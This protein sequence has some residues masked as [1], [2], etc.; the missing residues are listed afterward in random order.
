MA[1][2]GRSK[3]DNQTIAAAVREELARKRISRAT[4]ASQARISLSSLEKALSGQRPFTDQSLIRIEEALNRRLRPHLNAA[5]QFAPESLGSYARPAVAWLE[6]DYLTLRPSFSDKNCLYAYRTQIGWDAGLSHLIFRE[7]DRIDSAFTQEG[8][9]SIPHQ[10]GQ[11]YL[12]TSKHGQYRLALLSRPTIG[13]ELHGLLTTLQ[14]GRGAQLTPVSMPI[15]LV[16][17][18]GFDHPVGFGKIEIGH[19]QHSAYFAK[20]ERTL[21]DSFAILLGG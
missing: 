14:S 4:L 20:L 8:A 16:P 5:N 11:I 6:G 12:V 17:I 21:A 13:G 18:A 9:V 15:V 2:P 19:P 3:E 10:S 1:E 7:S